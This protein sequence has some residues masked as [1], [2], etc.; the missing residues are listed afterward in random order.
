M[1]QVQNL[2]FSYTSNAPVLEEI[3][4]TVKK[5]EHVSVI[6]AS[7]CGKS[8]LLKLLYGILQPQQGSIFWG[9]E[10]IKGPDYKLVPGEPFIKYL[11]QDFDLMPYITVEENISE[12]LSVF[13]PDELKQRTEELLKMIEMEAFA[14]TKVQ[15]LSGGQQQQVALAR[16]LAQEPEILLLDEPFS[17]IDN[18][19]KGSLR[20][21]LFAHLRKK[22]ISC[23]VA[24][25]DTNDMLPFSDSAMVI[26][27]GKI[28]AHEEMFRLY[29]NPKEIEIASLFGEA[30]VIPMKLLK[31][32]SEIEASIIVYPHE[33][34][35]SN[36]SGL[37][38]AIK[39]NY[40]KGSHFLVEGVREDGEPLFFM[41]DEPLQTQSS[42]YLNVAIETINLRLNRTKA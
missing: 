22:N 30:N 10:E 2:S 27:Q 29:N 39:E 33:F 5:G 11:S 12:F 13:Y 7:G 8:T 32:Y 31:S 40:F 36:T 37:K 16:V 24:T 19:K 26:K 34:Q 9:E 25:H 6:G 1:L 28:Q 21:N 42:I 15:F 17:H 20:R 4:F 18:F 41:F 14:K 23:I 38:V 3:S 35:I